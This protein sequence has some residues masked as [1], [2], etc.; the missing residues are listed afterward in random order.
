MTRIYLVRHGQDKDNLLGILN[1]HRDAS[2]TQTGISQ[3]NN[4]SKKIK[5]LNIQFD[6]VYTSPLKRTQ[7]TA[8]IITKKLSLKNPEIL[9]ILIER[10]FGIMSG[11]LAKNIESIC[12]SDVIKTKT[13][14]YFL[15][16]EG[17]E[18]FPP[19]YQEIKRSFKINKQ[20]S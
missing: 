18:T 4:L 2:L 17:A 1:G 13:V 11:K 9:D 3:A 15:S 20:K 8:K 14:T 19:T 5:K 6:K 10:D 12:H 7:Q 16:P